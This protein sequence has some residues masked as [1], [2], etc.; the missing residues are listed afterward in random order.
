MSKGSGK[1]GI[2]PNIIVDMDGN[3]KKARLVQRISL[4]SLILNILLAAAM[5]VTGILCRSAAVVSDGLNTVS[6]IA[7]TLIVIIGMRFAYKKADSGHPYG[8]EKIETVISMLLGLALLATAGYILYTG[9]YGMIHIENKDIVF[10]F[11][12]I[13]AGV[14]VVIKE[15]MFQYTYRIGKKIDSV[16]LK[17]DAWHHR[18]DVLSSATVIV[19]LVFAYFGVFIAE[20]IACALISVLIGI[21]AVKILRSGAGQM[22][23]ESAPAETVEKISG[24]ILQ[25]EGVLGIETIKTRKYADKLFVDLD[26]F[27]DPG[28][29]LKSAHEISHT[30]HDK[31]EAEFN[32][33]HVQIHCS[34]KED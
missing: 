28:I 12:F 23:D 29:S 4:I 32:I 22:L 1:I 26:L 31:L 27:L 7:T 21:Q 19:G 9:I 20:Y 13:M 3:D 15:I 14:S 5:V 30:V 16:I 2:S 34:P 6:D 8:H 18:S 10:N 25:V 33:K 17:A 24:S 11:T